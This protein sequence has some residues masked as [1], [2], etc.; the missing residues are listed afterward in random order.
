MLGRQVLN[1]L[2]LLGKIPILSHYWTVL[3]TSLNKPWLIRSSQ[4]PKVITCKQQDI[5]APGDCMDKIHSSKLNIQN[6]FQMFYLSA[7]YCLAFM[8]LYAMFIKHLDVFANKTV[9]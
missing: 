8:F 2:H 4:E 6:D 5:H 7:R 3:T 9:K 1:L